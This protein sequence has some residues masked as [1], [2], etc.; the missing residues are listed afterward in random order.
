VNS[1]RSRFEL[2]VQCTSRKDPRLGWKPLTATS[3]P[4]I[5]NVDKLDKRLFDLGLSSLS[6]LSIGVGIK[7]CK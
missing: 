1:L 5:D 2:P 6:T 7:P 3:A 4:P